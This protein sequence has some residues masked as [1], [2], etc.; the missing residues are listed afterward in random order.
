MPKLRRRSVRSLQ[1]VGELKARDTKTSVIPVLL[2]YSYNVTYLPRTDQSTRFGYKVVY[3][4]IRTT[5]SNSISVPSSFLERNVS[6]VWGTYSGGL[7]RS[8]GTVIQRL[9]RSTVAS[10]R[11]HW[12]TMASIGRKS[13]RSAK[14]P[15][16]NVPISRWALSSMSNGN[17][18]YRS[19]TY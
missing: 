2:S 17:L 18:K 16:G 15:C 6:E 14:T 7:T 8:I 11:A 19:I 9:F 13:H 12:Q 10:K 3:C 4:S 5:A 1:R